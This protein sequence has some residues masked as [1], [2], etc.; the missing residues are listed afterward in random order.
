MA[1]GEVVEVQGA[2][3]MYEL[4]YIYGVVLFIIWQVY[5]CSCVSWKQQALPIDIRTCKH[6]RELD[7]LTD[8]RYLGDEFENERTGIHAQVGGFLIVATQTGGRRTG[9][10]GSQATSGT[11]VGPLQCTLAVTPRIQRVGG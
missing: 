5:S 7:T 8:C 10:K 11:Q 2:S 9:K 1:E 6:L 3:G 4:K